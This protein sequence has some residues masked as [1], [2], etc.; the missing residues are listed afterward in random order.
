MLITLDDAIKKIKENKKIHFAG[1]ENLLNQLPQGNWIGGTIPYFMDSDGGVI[2]KDKIFATDIPDYDIKIKCYSENDLEDIT[3]DAPDNG[4]SLVIIPATSKAHVTYAQNAPGYKDIFLKP[5]IGWISGIHLDE[6]GKTSP[7]VFNGLTGEITDQ[8]A[9]VMH[10][11]LPSN[12]IAS[13]GIINLFKQGNSDTITFDTNGFSV[14][15]CFINGKKNNFSEYLLSNNI[16]IKLPL[17]ANYYGAMI[18]VSFQEIKKDEKTVNLYAPV[19]KGVEY[20]IA[21]PVSDY[22]ADF[23]KAL[24]A[25]SINPVFSCNCILNFL[26]SELEGKKTGN[27]LGP[28][29]FGEVAYQLLNQTLT[30]LEI[31]D[32]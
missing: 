12:K 16:D 30:Y 5:I 11:T 17:V 20:K 8:K 14:K 7:K 19:F 27:V 13:I 6:M 1:E 21:I 24:S 4:F 32:V 15:D 25:G 26:Y 28:I 29:T 31:K 2:S 9:V 22:V 3:A 10:I 23:Q 18:N